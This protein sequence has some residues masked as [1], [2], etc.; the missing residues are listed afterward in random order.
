MSSPVGPGH[1]K[2]RTG[3]TRRNSWN[4]MADLGL[5]R[6]VPA[7]VLRRAGVAPDLLG[8]HPGRSGEGPSLRFPSTAAPFPALVVADIGSDGQKQEVLPRIC[9]GSLIMT[10]AFQEQDP[11]L[12]PSAVNCAATPDGDGYVINGVKNFVDNFVVAEKC[13]VVCRT[14]PA[15]DDNEGLVLFSWLTPTCPAFPT[16]L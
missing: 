8:P 7:G 3:I 9:S 2:R 13:L 6:Y 1:G 11:R 10:W 14:A 16:R 15:S 12:L 4:K 5:V